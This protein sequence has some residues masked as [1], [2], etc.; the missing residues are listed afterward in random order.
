MNIELGARRICMSSVGYHT[1]AFPSSSL[2]FSRPFSMNVSANINSSDF[3]VLLP[4]LFIESLHLSPTVHRR[5]RLFWDYCCTTVWVVSHENQCTTVVYHFSHVR[6]ECSS[7]P[8]LHSLCLRPTNSRHSRLHS[9]QFCGSMRSRLEFT[10]SA[11]PRITPPFVSSPHPFCVGEGVAMV[12]SLVVRAALQQRYNRYPSAHGPTARLRLLTRLAQLA[13]FPLSRSL[14]SQICTVSLRQ[15]GTYFIPPSPHPIISLSVLQTAI[16]AGYRM[17]DTAN[18]YGNVR[19]T[20]HL[21]PFLPLHYYTACISPA[22]YLV[23]LIHFAVR[24]T[25]LV[26]R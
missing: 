25:R 1:D 6:C 22:A 5:A 24:S 12:R 17:I 16:R 2:H 4:G 18:D 15:P 19:V 21:A 8:D 3:T 20:S 9:V 23:P 14:S 11:R 7:L 13:A 10:L 26:R